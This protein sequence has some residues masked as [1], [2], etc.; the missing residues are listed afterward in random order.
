MTAIGKFCAGLPGD[1][2]ITN[3]DGTKSAAFNCTKTCQ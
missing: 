3:I 2:V 1:I